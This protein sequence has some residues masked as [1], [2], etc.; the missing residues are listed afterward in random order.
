MPRLPGAGA[1]DAVLARRG[2]AA[3]RGGAPTARQRARRRARGRAR[4]RRLPPAD[5]ALDAR[6]R[7]LV[8]RADAGDRPAGPLDAYGPGA[9]AQHPPST[10][11]APRAA[12]RR[13]P[14]QRRRGRG[15]PQRSPRPRAVDARRRAPRRADRGLAR[16]DLP[17]RAVAGRQ[18]RPPR[19][20]AGV[21]RHDRP[22]RRLPGHRGPRGTRPGPA[23]LH[24][25][26]VRARAALRAA[27]PRRPR[28]AGL[29]ARPRGARPHEPVPASPRRPRALVPLPPPLRA[30]PP[31]RAGAPRARARR[32]AASPRVRVARRARHR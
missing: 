9:A 2:G 26:H 21:R 8:R 28:R 4:P 1:R 7:R 18:R 19:P 10:G 12:R 11:P 32:G 31:R 16:G 25:A 6:E 13:P 20:R 14:L 22:R 23:A 29:V 24:A 15:V 30:D 3:A 27:V 5:R 17:G